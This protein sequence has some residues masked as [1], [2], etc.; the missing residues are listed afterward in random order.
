VGAAPIVLVPGFWLGAWA[1]D[2]VVDRLRADGHDV[3]ALTLPGREPDRSDRGSVTMAEQADAICAAIE[4]A[5][6]PVVLAVHSG[7]SQ[8]GFE[9]TARM[10]DRIAHMVYVD[11]APGIGP[12]KPDFEDDELPV[13]S[14]DDLAEDEN[15]DGLTDDHLAELQSRGVPEPGSSLT[16][17]PDLGDDDGY[18]NVPSTVIA[19]G[20]SSDQ[21][22]AAVESGEPWMAGLKELS[23]L[24]WI[25]LPTS[26]WPMWSRPDELAEILARI[27]TEAS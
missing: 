25:D 13:P 9:A 19:T 26:H 3:T 24:R 23:D 17:G 12:I 16:Q 7:S 18:R 11:T 5:G 14:T 10:P 8:P 1:W 6:A 15:L 21:Y 22:K 20:F 4:S 2:A 27:A